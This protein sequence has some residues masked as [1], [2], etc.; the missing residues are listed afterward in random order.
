VLANTSVDVSEVDCRKCGSCV[1]RT[2]APISTVESQEETHLGLSSNPVAPT[3]FRNEPFGENV[4]GL[5]Y[6]GDKSCSSQ[7]V[8]K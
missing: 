5:S 1:G 3:F 8:F 2:E 7:I 4:E 6:C